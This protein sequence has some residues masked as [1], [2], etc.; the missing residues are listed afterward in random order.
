MKEATFTFRVDEGK[1]SDGRK[2]PGLYEG[3]V[4]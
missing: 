3:A 1:Q 4:L 2:V